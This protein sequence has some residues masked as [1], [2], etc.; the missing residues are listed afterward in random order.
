MGPSPSARWAGL[1]LPP[2]SPEPVPR[3]ENV[4]GAV[5]RPESGFFFLAITFHFLSYSSAV[6]YRDCLLAPFSFMAFLILP[7][8]CRTGVGRV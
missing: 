3:G 8:T 2:G 1:G 6:T 5:F 7:D 4:F